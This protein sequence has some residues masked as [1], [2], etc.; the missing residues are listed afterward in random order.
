[1]ITHRY[2]LVCE[3]V[4]VENT[5]KFI[6]LGLFTNGI[7]TTQ[8]PFPLPSLTFFHALQIQQ[9]GQ[10]KFKMRVSHLDNG[11]LIAQVE[12]GFAAP[13]AAEIAFPIKI[14][15]PQFNAFGIYTVSLEIEG[16]PEPFLT[17]FQVS[18]VTAPQVRIPV[19]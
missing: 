18:L 6:I 4:R 10:F 11:N 7:G 19:R 15:N 9:P 2:T 3:D 1:M 14:P 17:Q 12:G 13:Q 16:Q 8:I 5:G